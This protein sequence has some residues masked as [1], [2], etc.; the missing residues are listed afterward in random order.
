MKKCTFYSLIFER[1]P[2]AKL[3]EGYTDGIFNYYRTKPNA[4]VWWAIEPSTG[5]G[6]ATGTSRKQAATRATAPEKL[7]A[8]GEKITPQMI[9]RFTEL[10]QAAEM[11]Q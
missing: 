1:K 10:R 2:V 7:K 3:H 11:E 6:V 8:C 5:L 4:G 9:Q